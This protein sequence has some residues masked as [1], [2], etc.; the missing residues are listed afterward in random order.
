MLTEGDIFS[1]IK[2]R[3]IHQSE[4]IMKRKRLICAISGALALVMLILFIFFTVSALSTTSEGKNIGIIGGADDGGALLTEK[5]AAMGKL[6]PILSGVLFLA[7]A[8][9]FAVSLIACVKE[10]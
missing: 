4:E 8:A 3:N 5:L 1:K 9:I 10:K 6:P 7:F 2:G